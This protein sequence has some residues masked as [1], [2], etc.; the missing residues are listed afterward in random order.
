MDRSKR[1]KW[2][3]RLRESEKLFE[4]YCA[5]FHLQPSSDNP[6]RYFLF[7]RARYVRHGA[8]PGSGRIYGHDVVRPGHVVQVILETPLNT[9]LQI[10]TPE[11]YAKR[12]FFVI[13]A[14]FGT[15]QSQEVVAS[16]MRMENMEGS[17][18]V[19]GVHKCTSNT[20]QLLPLYENVRRAGIVYMKP[21]GGE[22]SHG[23]TVHLSAT[24][25]YKSYNQY[26]RT[27]HSS[28]ERL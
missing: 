1:S 18:N 23:I 22:E 9:V 2:P 8:S 28:N 20:V 27:V 26:H 3:S 25:K 12:Y 6:E 19:R 16:V 14:L 17:I 15:Y 24:G 13:I 10:P 5:G 7:D 4:T 11:V 21:E